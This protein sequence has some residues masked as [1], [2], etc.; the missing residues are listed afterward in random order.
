MPGNAQ[1]PLSRSIESVVL[2]KQPPASAWKPPGWRL[3]P[4]DFSCLGLNSSSSFGTIRTSCRPSVHRSSPI[5]CLSDPAPEQA[6]I[7]APRTC[8]IARDV[9]YNFPI[10]IQLWGIPHVCQLGLRT[11]TRFR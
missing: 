2:V 11:T 5:R 3:C 1:R 7:P 6:Q 10:A 4:E 9:Q 8:R